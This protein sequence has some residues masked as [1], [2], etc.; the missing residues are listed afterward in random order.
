MIVKNQLNPAPGAAQEFFSSEEDGA[1]IMVNLL[2]FREKAEYPDDSD[3]H[4]TGREAYSRYGMAVQECLQKV[5]ARSI[6]AGE[7][8]GLL[9]GEVEENWDMVAAV[10]YPSLEAMRTMVAS[11]E[12]AAAAV[13]RMSVSRDN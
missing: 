5:G 7:V 9:L 11:P 13:H 2:K 6:F 1:F 12:Y 3:A 8:T 4:L 10:E